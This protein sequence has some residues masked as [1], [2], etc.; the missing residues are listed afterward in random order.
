MDKIIKYNNWCC[1][2]IGN[3]VLELE[4]GLQLFLLYYVQ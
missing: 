3:N 4:D 1:S 2:G